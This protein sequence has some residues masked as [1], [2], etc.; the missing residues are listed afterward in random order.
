ECPDIIGHLDL[1]KKNNKQDKFFSETEGWYKEIVMRTLKTIAGSKAIIEVNT[2]G[3]TRKRCDAL[4]P[5]LW[6]LENIL[7]LNIPITLNSDAHNPNELIGHFKETAE[8]LKNIGFKHIY[9]LT[10]EGWKACNFS[11][12]GLE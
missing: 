12:T 4:Y 2:G 10:D 1:I 9:V 3:L 7:K 6:I 8:V 5:S 11:V